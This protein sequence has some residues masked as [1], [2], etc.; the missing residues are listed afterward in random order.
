[1]VRFGGWVGRTCFCQYSLRIEGNTMAKNK[2]KSY[3]VYLPVELIDSKAFQSLKGKLVQFLLCFYQRRIFVTRK[4]GKRKQK[5]CINKDEIVFTYAEGKALGFPVS[6]FMRYQKILTDLGFIDIAETGAGLFRSANIYS[7]SDR[8]EKY[9]TA[10]YIPPGKLPRAK[11]GFK[12]GH[13]PYGNQNKIVTE[14]GNG[15]VTKTGNSSA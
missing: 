12:K 8:W 10:G 4:I 2:K 15:S 5:V 6:T 14:I 7:I 1:M 3:G 9:G 11:I 13:R